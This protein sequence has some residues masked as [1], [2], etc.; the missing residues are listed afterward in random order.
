M[1]DERERFERAFELFRM[2][3]PSWDRLLRRRDRKQRNKRIATVVLALVVAAFAFGLTAKA[4]FG[5]RS[6]PA[7]LPDTPGAWSVERLPRGQIMCCENGIHSVTAGGPGLVAVGSSDG[8]LHQNGYFLDG[9]ASVWVSSDGERWTHLIG[10]ELGDGVIED[11]TTGGP[12]LVAVGSDGGTTD[13]RH[14]GL[15]PGNPRS[16]V[17][18]TSPDGRTWTR[19]PDDPKVFGGATMQAVAQGGSGLVAV[20]H[21]GYSS[22]GLLPKAEAWFSSDG[23]TWARTSVAGS[24]GHPMGDVTAFGNGF[25]AV[26]AG[27]AFDGGYIWTSD[28]GLKW[29]QVKDPA[30]AGLTLTG[31]TDGPD[32]LVAVGFTGVSGRP[33]NRSPA[34]LTSTDGLHWSRVGPGQQAFVPPTPADGITWSLQPASVTSSSVGYVA[35]GT[36]SGFACQ[37][38]ASAG[39]DC[40]YGLEVTEAS[41]W[42]SPDGRSW[43]RV[44]RDPVFQGMHG[45]G[46]GL[47]SIVSVTTWKSHLVAVGLDDEAVGG[48]N[49]WPAIWISH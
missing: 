44:L 26:G 12:G 49:H 13:A 37:G 45:P 34:V 15:V 19:R 16:A 46:S 17:V 18:W 36:A 24:Y 27:N 3:E 47:V 7:N 29:T 31:V 35:V 32:G 38:P 9:P 42:T 23:V 43:T 20:G 48:N 1:I 41:V 14:N 25:V 33:D 21:S 22:I 11:V 4:F 2:P 39:W 5:D 30:L 8:R 40:P 10:K 28:D 6:V